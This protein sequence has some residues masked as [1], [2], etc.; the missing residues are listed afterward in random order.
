MLE[1]EIDLLSC[2]HITIRHRDI[3]NIVKSFYYGANQ[4]MAYYPPLG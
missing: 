1:F 3:D 4:S 2:D